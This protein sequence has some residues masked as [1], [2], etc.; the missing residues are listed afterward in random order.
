M[1]SR[2]AIRPRARRHCTDRGQARKRARA[3][4][5][6]GFSRTRIAEPGRAGQARGARRLTQAPSPGAT[7]AAFAPAKINLYLHI[8]GR[9]ADGYHLLDSLIAF[10]DIG[11]QIVAAPADTLS[12]TVSGSEAGAL[13]GL[14]DDNLVLRAARAFAAHHGIAAGAALHLTKN[15]P[16]A[17]GIG[18]GSS[19]AAA[20]LRALAALWRRPL[21]DAATRIAASLGADIPACLDGRPVWVSGIGE[22]LDPL[23]GLPPLGIVLANPR[24][25]LPTAA[26]F[27]ARQGEFTTDRFVRTTP[28]HAVGLFG[29]LRQ[30][31]NDLTEAAQSLMPEIGGMLD[32]LAALPG[33]YLARMSG[34]GATCLALF[35]DRGTADHAAA[36]LVAA[37]PGWW[38]S[39]GELLSS[40]PSVRPAGQTGSQPN[41]PAGWQAG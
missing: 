21:D 23:P 31:R 39:A 13:A 17:S 30:C 9:R 29:L 18:G 20:T 27:G 7:V 25:E 19:D 6:P 1:A 8:V 3:A 35:A 16:V 38:V 5:D 10:A 2:A 37:Q 40:P 12:L 11:D 33:A 34:S 22:R 24:R 41:F 32:R 36:A 14:G 15:L 4:F 26:V 28:R